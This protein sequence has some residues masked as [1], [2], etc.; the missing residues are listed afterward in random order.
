MAKQNQDP[1]ASLGARRQVLKFAEHSCHYSPQDY[2]DMSTELLDASTTDADH[3]RQAKDADMYLKRAVKKHPQDRSIAMQGKAARVKLAIFQGKEERAKAL[4][5]E[6]KAIY[7]NGDGDP[8][9]ELELAEAMD[10][11]GDHEGAT[12]LMLKVARDNPD[13]TDLADRVDG[14]SEEPVSKKG[15]KMAANLTKDGISH[16][17]NKS[18]DAA[19]MVF[20]RATGLF[21]KHVGLRLNIIHV[22]LTQSK[23]E[24]GSDHLAALCR[25]NMAHI[26]ELSRGHRQY[27]RYQQLRQELARLYPT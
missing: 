17:E 5:G 3:R 19:I 14:L 4:I 20:T 25:E 22:A 15:K 27:P 7:S 6:A 1:K 21:P 12:A 8:Y 10:V 16:F 18:Y 9:A 13:N 23:E 2:F 26:G 11:T 24:Q